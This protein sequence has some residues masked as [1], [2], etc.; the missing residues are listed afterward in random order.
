MFH[1]RKIISFSENS[2]AYG[3]VFMIYLLIRG[4]RKDTVKNDFQLNSNWNKNC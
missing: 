1:C 3:Y 2:S 4:Q